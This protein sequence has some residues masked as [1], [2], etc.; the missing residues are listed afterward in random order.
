MIPLALFLFLSPGTRLRRLPKVFERCNRLLVTTWGHD[1][2]EIPVT[3]ALTMLLDALQ[4]S[5]ILVQ[6]LCKTGECEAKTKT[7]AFP[8]SEE[9]QGEIESKGIFLN[10]KIPLY[11]WVFQIRL[12]EI[13]LI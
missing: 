2:S 3:G 4:H 12:V 10:V 6:A 11:F 13:L 7:V 9:D 5:P 1:P 8:I